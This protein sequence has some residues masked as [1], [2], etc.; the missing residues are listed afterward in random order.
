M[1]AGIVLLN[2]ID[3][4]RAPDQSQIHWLAREKKNSLCQ[5]ASPGNT[6]SQA[7]SHRTVEETRYFL[8]G[9]RGGFETPLKCH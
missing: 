8:D 6:F 9:C 5:C 7:V 4:E 2:S 3:D 1:D